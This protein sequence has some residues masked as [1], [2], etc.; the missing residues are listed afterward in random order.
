MDARP[1]AGLR[2]ADRINVAARSRFSC[3][4]DK[5]AKILISHKGAPVSMTR[6][7]AIAER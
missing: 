6:S 4:V 7:A 5:G 2:L 3:E 1:A